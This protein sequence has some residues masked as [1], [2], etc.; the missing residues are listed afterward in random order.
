MGSARTLHRSSLHPEPIYA[1]KNLVFYDRAS[2]SLDHSAD[3]DMATGQLAERQAPPSQNQSLSSNV[4]FPD[5][6]SEYFSREDSYMNLPFCESWPPA[7]SSSPHLDVDPDLDLVPSP[8]LDVGMIDLSSPAYIQL[9]AAGLGDEANS[10][11]SAAA[12]FQAEAAT[13]VQY[14]PLCALDGATFIRLTEDNDCPQTETF[15]EEKNLVLGTG[16]DTLLAGCVSL[17]PKQQEV[18]PSKLAIDPYKQLRPRMPVNQRSKIKHCRDVSK[19]DC[20][21]KFTSEKV[22]GDHIR[23]V[24]GMR[25]YPCTKPGCTYR[26]AR[27]DNLAGHQKYCSPETTVK[28]R[29]RASSQLPDSSSASTRW[30]KRHYNTKNAQARAFERRPQ[31]LSIGASP[32]SH[33][34]A[35]NDKGTISFDPFQGNG[36]NLLHFLSSTLMGGAILSQVPSLQSKAN[37]AGNPRAQSKGAIK[38]ENERLRAENHQYQW[39]LREMLASAYRPNNYKSED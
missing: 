22:L 26:A 13:G 39:I 28:K 1:A 8:N 14:D 27:Y 35:N 16:A 11:E 17:Q 3:E 33:T 19:L 34:A 38:A 4:T 20:D 7:T 2:T 5:P 30:S 12:I 6:Q 24:H 29:P 10:I 32:L 31:S 23:D 25:A 15:G 9:Q 36:S 21:M 37:L 18:V